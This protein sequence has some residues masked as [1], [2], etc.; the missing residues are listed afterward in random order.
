MVIRL[1]AVGPEVVTH[2]SPRFLDVG[3]EPG[4]H[5]LKCRRFDE[6]LVDLLLCQAKRLEKRLGD[7]SIPV[8]DFSP[9]H[10]GVHDR[11]NPGA[12]KVIALNLGEIV[13]EAFHLPSR[14]TKAGW[15]SGG[16]KRIDFP[17]ASIED[18]VR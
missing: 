2:L 8:V 16:V 1:E 4:Q 15:H 6:I 17:F 14:I 3:R 9:N 5:N 7:P 10:Y 12:A 13:E 18:S 11:K